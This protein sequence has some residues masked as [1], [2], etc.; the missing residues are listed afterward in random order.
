MVPR[1]QSSQPLALAEG[2]SAT[3]NVTVVAQD[4]IAK[5]TYLVAVTRQPSAS[6]LLSGPVPHPGR[7]QDNTL[8]PAL[9]CRPL[10]S[11][12]VSPG[13]VGW[14]IAPYILQ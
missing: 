3:M 2:S 1:G 14:Y 4:G 13:A 11:S 7:S 9:S 6:P 5:M 10:T 8:T 12:L